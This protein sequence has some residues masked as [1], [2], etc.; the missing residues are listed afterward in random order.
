MKF[1]I[2]G[3]IKLNSNLKTY[4]SLAITL[5]LFTLSTVSILGVAHAAYDPVS[6]VHEDTITKGNWYPSAVGSPIGVYGSYAHILPN[7][8]VNLTQV[9]IGNFS[10]PIGGYSNLPNPPYN[11]TTSQIAGLPYW[12]PDPSYW[13]EYQSQSPQVTYFTNGTFFDPIKV[14]IQYPTFEWA[15]NSP[16]TSQGSDARTVFYP[17][18]NMWRLAAW[19]DGGERSF[20]TH[21]Y[22]NFTLFFPGGTYLLSLYAYD[23][24]RT[25]RQSE[26]YLI[27]DSTGT[28]LLASKQISGTTFDE[29]VFETFNVTAPIGGLTI[30]L[31]VYNDAGH[32]ANTVNVVLSGIFVDK[33]RSIGGELLPEGWLAL[34]PLI[35]VLAVSSAAVAVVFAFKKLSPKMMPLKY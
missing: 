7:P 4:T 30:I 35:A 24:E 16:Q 21:G 31:Q 20:P 10:V 8:P 25:S 22:M 34:G 32:P 23:Y 13:D 3:Q 18:A 15:W 1:Y 5:L 19:D 9:P 2:K 14:M 6:W 28:Q 29:G 26:E 11:W 17:L 33:L 12:K 27:Y